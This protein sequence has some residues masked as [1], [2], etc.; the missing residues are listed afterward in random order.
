MA[1]VPI[2]VCTHICTHVHNNMN[3]AQQTETRD[4]VTLSYLL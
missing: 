1:T 4:R 2:S 3:N